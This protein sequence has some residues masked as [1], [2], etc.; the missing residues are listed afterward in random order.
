MTPYLTWLLLPFALLL[1]AASLLLL[2]QGLANLLPERGAP[3]TSSLVQVP[4]Y[5]VLMPAHNEEAIIGATV[6]ATLARMGPTGRLLVI[7]DNCTDATAKR[8]RA[9]GAEVSE[10]HHAQEKGKGFALAHGITQLTDSP[11]EVVVVLDADC[12]VDGD[13]IETLVVQAHA[14]QRPIQARYDMLAPH[15]AGLKQRMAAF[16]WDFRGRFRA[17]GFR[18]AGLPCQLMGSGMAFPWPLLERVSLA[19]GHLVEDLKLGMDCA[20]VGRTPLLYPSAVVSSHFPTN[21]QGA[22]SQRQRWEHG[23]LSMVFSQAPPLFWKAL[24]RGNGPM[25]AMVLDMCVPPLAL[26]V[27]LAVMFAALVAVLGALGWVSAWLA[28]VGAVNLALIAFPVL[29]GWWCVGRRWIGIG[30]L[31]TAPAYVLRK[32]PVYVGFVFRRQAQW[33][34]TRRD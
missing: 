26:L 10:R 33:I 27:L 7:A 25:L 3:A 6:R 24:C 1:L 2:F 4:P 16:A 30:E 21:E 12:A 32:I 11:P 5:V 17:E 34:R 8:A 19:S 29:M 22:R 23:H 28:V 15:G 20:L 13:A 9:A 14:R 31:L 18:R